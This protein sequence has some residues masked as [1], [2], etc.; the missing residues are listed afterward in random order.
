MATA[1]RKSANTLEVRSSTHGQTRP[2]LFLDR[3]MAEEIETAIVDEEIT[4][5]LGDIT[6]FNKDNGWGKLKIENGTKTVS[7]SIPYDIL[8]TMKQT[9]I[10][11]M[12]RDLVYLQ[13]Y[14]VRDRTDEVIRLIA[15]GILPTPTA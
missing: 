13:T 9:L 14:F 1:L 8:P 5:I 6:Q 11:N 10:D 2:V 7:F 4:P 3:K 12:K 15:V